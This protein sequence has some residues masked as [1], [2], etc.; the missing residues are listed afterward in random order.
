[1]KYPTVILIGALLLPAFAI[2]SQPN[3]NC[4]HGSQQTSGSD[5][6]KSMPDDPNNAAGRDVQ[7][8][9]NPTRAITGESQQSNP[10]GEPSGA[11]GAGQQG[12][13]QAPEEIPDDPNNAAGRDVQRGGN[14]TRAITGESQ[15]S[16]PQGETQTAPPTQR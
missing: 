14:P 15:Q 3:S 11:A 13:A 8:G 6:S 7:R 12:G 1:M 4:H 9:G 2:A 5:A 10:Q 16:N